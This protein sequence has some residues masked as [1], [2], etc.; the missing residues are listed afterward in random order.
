MSS[1]LDKTIDLMRS[2]DIPVKTVCKDVDLSTEW[3]HKV[4]AGKIRDPGVRRIERLHSYL[5]SRQDDHQ[6]EV[7]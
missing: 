2:T 7:A 6:Q 1:L 3:Y 4:L 5:I